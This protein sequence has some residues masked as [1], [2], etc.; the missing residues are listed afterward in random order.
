[1]DLLW[2][3]VHQSPQAYGA[4][5]DARLGNAE[6]Q[7]ALARFET[8]A[9][10]NP[11][12]ALARTVIEGS[13]EF[14]PP[15]YVSANACHFKD[16]VSDDDLGDLASHIQST[17][18]SLEAWKGVP[19]YSFAP[20]TG[21]PDSMDRV[22]FT[23]HESAT[24]WAERTGALVTSDAGQSLYRHFGAL[25]SCNAGHFLGERVLPVE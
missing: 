3:T 6:M 23:V 16:G 9:D 15:T 5:T 10:C 8:V 4:S 13:I 20:L 19:F 17:L 25:M 14:K 22:L 18:G 1:M 2:M 11:G 24:K 12:L 7:A 21:G